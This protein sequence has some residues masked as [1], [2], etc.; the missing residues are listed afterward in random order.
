V[1]FTAGPATGAAVFTFKIT[2]SF[3]CM[4]T[5]T[6]TL[7]CEMPQIEFCALTQGFYG[8]QG[9]KFGCDPD[10]HTGCVGMT[11]TRIMTILLSAPF[12]DLTVGK[13]GHSFTLRSSNAAS[14][15][16]CVVKKLPAN[17][18]PT[19]LPAGDGHFD[20]PN[21][22]STTDSIPTGA[23]GKWLNVLLGQ[24]ITLSFNIRYDAFLHGGPPS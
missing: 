15:A 1:H 11:S 8:N 6:Q 20:N 9:G 21:S 2:D 7:S 14:D 10:V 5:C 17:S 22:C 24:T 19:T 13:P 23:G 3:N 12:G 4:S 16:A 18:T